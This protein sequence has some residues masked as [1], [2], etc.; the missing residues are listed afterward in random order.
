ML[1]GLPIKAFDHFDCT[2]DVQN[3]RGAKDGSAFWTTVV[4]FCCCCFFFFFFFLF[5]KT[6]T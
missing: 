6:V 1:F 4:F 2:A 3:A 5:F